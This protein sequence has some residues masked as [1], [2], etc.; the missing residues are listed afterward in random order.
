M[1]ESLPKQDILKNITQKSVKTTP[2]ET[3]T[4]GAIE[5]HYKKPLQRD[6]KS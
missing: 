3:I 4:Q 1:K 2:T 6:S 5:K